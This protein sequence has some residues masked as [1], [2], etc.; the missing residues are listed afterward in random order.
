MI[1]RKRIMQLTTLVLIVALIFVLAGCGGKFKSGSY[2]ETSWVGTIIVD[3]EKTTSP[4]NTETKYSLEIDGSNIVFKSGDA[5]FTGT[6]QGDEI[7]WTEGYSFYDDP[8]E[9]IGVASG[10]ALDSTT[11]S[12]S[13]GNDIIIAFTASEDLTFFGYSEYGWV[14]SYYFTK[15]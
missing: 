3:G 8:W 12:K 4:V 11:I 9:Y 1:C 7:T 2:T 5:S 14:Y 13:N 15:A 10:V 6:I